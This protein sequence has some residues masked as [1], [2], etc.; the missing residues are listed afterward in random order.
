MNGKYIL[1]RILWSNMSQ[2]NVSMQELVIIQK[3]AYAIL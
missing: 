3:F 2:Y 1:S